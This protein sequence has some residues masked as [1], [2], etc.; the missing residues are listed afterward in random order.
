MYSIVTFSNLPKTFSIM[1]INKEIEIFSAMKEL[2]ESPT[3]FKQKALQII[4]NDLVNIEIE[5]FDAIKGEI[6]DVG[7]I[8][9]V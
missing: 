6:E 7:N 5:E 4:A 9:R 3:Y 1:D 2:V 8:E